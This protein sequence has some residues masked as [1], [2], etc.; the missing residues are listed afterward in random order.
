MGTWI[1]KVETQGNKHLKYDEDSQGRLCRSIPPANSK[2]RFVTAPPP[3][4][5]LMDHLLSTILR[6]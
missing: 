4:D 3:T 6:T 1:N 2:K 5:T